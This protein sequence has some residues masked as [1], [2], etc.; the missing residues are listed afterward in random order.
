MTKKNITITC[1]DFVEAQIQ[2]DFI[3]KVRLHGGR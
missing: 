2:K 3:V 1:I